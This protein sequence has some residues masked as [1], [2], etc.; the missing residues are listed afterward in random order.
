MVERLQEKGHVVV[1]EIVCL[2]RASP[3]VEG[4]V[5]YLDEQ[6]Q[7]RQ[8]LVVPYRLVQSLDQAPK[9]QR[10]AGHVEEAGVRPHHIDDLFR[11]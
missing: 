6:V 4:H 9:A 5:E 11:D 7:Y 10:R 2:L 1:Q 3:D 8:F